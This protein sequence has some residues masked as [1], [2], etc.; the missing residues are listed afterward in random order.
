MKAIGGEIELKSTSERIFFTDSGRSSIRLLLRSVKIKKILIPDFLCQIII[1]IIK[2]ENI[3]YQ[4]YSLNNDFTIDTN[5]FTPD[6]DALYLVNHFGINHSYLKNNSSLNDM[7]II[8]DNVFS[9]FVDNN[10]D[11]NKWYSFN[12]YRKFS[13]C[14]EGSLIKTNLDL[15]DKSLINKTD[16]KF[17]EKRY[18]AKELKSKF[19]SGSKIE[20]SE[21]LELSSQ[22]EYELD[23]QQQIHQLSQLGIYNL[24]QFSSKLNSEIEIRN[25]NYKILEQFLSPIIIENIKFKS[26]FVLKSERLS[27]IKTTLIKNKIYLPGFWPNPY[28]I[29]SIFYNGI[30]A[31][32]IDSRYNE[33]DMERVGK[34]I[35]SLID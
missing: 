12:S 20:E 6:F 26:F 19:I 22:S 15:I 25:K 1:D 8:E 5:Q 17:I 4:I 31:I 3:D 29:N 21:F 28:K 18:L 24:M 30:I 34:L 7:I 27:E 9:P 35:K 2:E 11:A 23:S 33:I 32:P 14:V 16:S 13:Y 10:L